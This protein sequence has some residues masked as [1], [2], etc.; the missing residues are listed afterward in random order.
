ME[1]CLSFMILS[2]TFCLS[3]AEFHCD[4]GYLLYG[5]YCYHFNSESDKTWQ[6]A[7]NY[8]SSQ[9]GHLASVHNQE[10]VRFITGLLAVGPE[11]AG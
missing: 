4:Q 9:N 8:C 7:E 1:I 5:D 6:D 11:S 10:T 2:S 3:S